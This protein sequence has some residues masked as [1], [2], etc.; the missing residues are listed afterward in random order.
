VLREPLREPSCRRVQVVGEK[1]VERGHLVPGL[2][3][4]EVELTLRVTD[5]LLPFAGGHRGPALGA[6]HVV[7]VGEEC[8]HARVAGEGRYSPYRPQTLRG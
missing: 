3:H 4:A 1:A 6:R 7:G 5:V 2:E 8:G